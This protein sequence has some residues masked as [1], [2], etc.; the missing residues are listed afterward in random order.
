ME[1]NKC[2]KCKNLLPFTT[3]PKSVTCAFCGFENELT[4]AKPHSWSKSNGSK[5]FGS[6][7][8]N[9]ASGIYGVIGSN[10]C[11]DSGSDC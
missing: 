9:E 10:D 2:T 4:M 3:N 8:S 6:T 5:A 1:E 11:G 7:S